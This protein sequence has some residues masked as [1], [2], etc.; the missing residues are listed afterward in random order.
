[1]YFE[2]FTVGFEFKT[3]S[4]TLTKSQIIEFAH[5]WDPQGF[6]INEVAALKSPFKG[7]IASG[8]HTL[9]VG[10]KLT[11]ETG[12]FEE[13]S[14]GSPGMEHV[15]WVLPVRPNDK[16]YIIGKVSALK[17]SR[18][19]PDRGFVDINYSIIANDKTL[20]C[21]YTATHILWIKGMKPL[22]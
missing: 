19:K 15:K 10:F 16:L 9:L 11:L 3:D 1:M 4:R 14:I 22:N 20:V 18:T 6:H 17:I 7:I 13:S 5:E 21:S 12:L 8:W 2:D